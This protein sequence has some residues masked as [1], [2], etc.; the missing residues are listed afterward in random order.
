MST[1][2][3]VR[4][5][6]NELF[7][8]RDKLQELENHD[9]VQL[10]LILGLLSPDEAAE[11]RTSSFSMAHRLEM[12]RQLRDTMLPTCFY[13]ASSRELLRREP[14]V[15][16]VFAM[17]AELQA[18]DHKGGWEGCTL[19]QMLDR[20]REETD[21]LEEA[22]ATLEDYQGESTDPARRHLQVQVRREAADVA[23]FAMMIHDICRNL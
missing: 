22:V 8:A 14:L 3:Q 18:N 20:L 10:D 15:R 4:V 13:G 23:N 5:E 7:A 9:L 2:N 11:G 21:E 6:L 16:F 17:E 19:R 12:V 1:L